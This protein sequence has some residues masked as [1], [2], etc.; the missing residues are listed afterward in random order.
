V[1]LIDASVAVK[2]ALEE[3]DYEAA[4]ELSLGPM[5][6]PE[7]I[8]AEAASAWW[9]A[10]RNGA[11]TADAY[12]AAVQNLPGLFDEL[13]SAERVMLRA[14]EMSR[15][16]DHP[17]YDCIYLALAE[18]RGRALITADRRLLKKIEATEFAPLCEP[19]T[20]K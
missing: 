13:H 17:I 6:A 3:A 10:W 19:L 11:L 16:L 15:I 12:D 7:L 4:R 20:D 2:F 18:D 14:A 9:K 8:L 5:C 1:K